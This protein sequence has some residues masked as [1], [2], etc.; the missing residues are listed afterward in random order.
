LISPKRNDGGL[1]Y[2][3]PDHITTPHAH[4]QT[5]QPWQAGQ[6]LIRYS[7]DDKLISVTLL[8]ES[9]RYDTELSVMLNGKHK[10]LKVTHE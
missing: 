6:D 7:D 2:R 8:G 9:F 3:W 5:D 1:I 10:S 4:G